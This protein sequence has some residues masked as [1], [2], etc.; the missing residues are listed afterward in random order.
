MRIAILVALVGAVAVGSASALPQK[1]VPEEI[2]TAV[3][4]F[5]DTLS[6]ACAS[7]KPIHLNDGYFIVCR[8]GT[9]I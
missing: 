7:G 2:A 3:A 4:E 8:K 1:C 6:K 9:S 5:V